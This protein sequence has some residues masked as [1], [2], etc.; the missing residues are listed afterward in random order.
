MAMDDEVA[1]RRLEEM[2]KAYADR[3]YAYAVGRVGR[4]L[5]RDVVSETYLVAWRKLE[6]VPDHALPWLL[7][8]ARNVIANERRSSARRTALHERL[9]A[10]TADTAF[11]DVG[12]IPTRHDIGAALGQL[13]QADQEPL[14]LSAWYGLTAR[15]AAQVLRCAPGTYAV[16]LHRA[17]RRLHRKL[18]HYENSTRVPATA[19][20]EGPT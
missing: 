6:V 10:I 19:D 5:G 15:E 9:A 4:D 13:D 17:R 11:D 18:T 12:A 8:T 1:A 16:R 14:I 2:F 7:C 20:Q 3:V